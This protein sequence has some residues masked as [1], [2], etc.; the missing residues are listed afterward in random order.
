[1]NHQSRNLSV[2]IDI[3]SK[4]NVIIKGNVKNTFKSVTIFAANTIDTKVSYSGSGLP[5]P[6]DEI[7]FENTPNIYELKDNTFNVSFSYPNSFYTSD[8]RIKIPPTIFF[9]F[10]DNNDTVSYES[11]K[12]IDNLTLKSLSYR[13]ADFTQ[14]SYYSFK[15]SVIPVGT[16]EYTMIENK[17]IKIKNNVA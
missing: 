1:M 6:N 17:K 12:L 4:K 15:E 8:H 13:H 3:D 14:P 9:K 2:N 11:I 7:A 5:F 10:V 16:A